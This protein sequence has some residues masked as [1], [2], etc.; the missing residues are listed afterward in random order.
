[1]P[2]NQSKRIQR[3][4]TGVTI[5]LV[6]AGWFCVFRNQT[7]T[8]SAQTMLSGKTMGTTYSVSFFSDSADISPDALKK[9]IDEELSR[10]NRVLSPYDKTSEISRF[11][12]SVSTEF[13]PVS[14][15]FVSVMTD[16]LSICE[17]TKGAFDPTVAAVV[18]LWGFGPDGRV[19]EPPN[20]EAVQAALQQCGWH[21]LALTNDRLRKAIPSLHLDLSAIA[22]GYGV[23][24]VARLLAQSGITNFVVEI[25]GEAVVSGYKPGG[26]G[27][28]IGIQKPR[29]HAQPGD[30]LAGF[31]ELTDAAVA[32]SGDYQNFFTD[33]RGTIYSHI[34]DPRTGRPVGHA[35][36]GV[37]VVA[38]TCMRA[39]GLATGLYVMGPDEGLA[40]VESLPGVEA[41]YILRTADGTFQERA[42]SGFAARTKYQAVA[43]P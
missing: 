7:A 8:T 43:A 4:L 23:D 17:L 28:R 24:A 35:T 12:G 10:L 11:N 2:V 5:A 38:D 19:T 36:A 14:E 40:L 33:A 31:L 13:I 9:E 29:Y 32:T 42:S 21:Q 37:T 39:D 34:M 26:K 15:D 20:E 18:N 25:G 30:E 6:C 1:M 3:L 27:W 22:K 16:A 41:L